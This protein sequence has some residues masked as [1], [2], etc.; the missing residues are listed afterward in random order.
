MLCRQVP[1]GVHGDDGLV[2]VPGG[3]STGESVA[4][5]AWSAAEWKLRMCNSD[6][7]FESRH[8]SDMIYVPRH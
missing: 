6:L 8:A 7:E 5:A 3:A 2:F 4:C 1:T